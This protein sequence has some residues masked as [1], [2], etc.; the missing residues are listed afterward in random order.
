MQ[1][2]ATQQGFDL[3]VRV[4]DD[5]P[6]INADPDAIEQALHNMISNA[7][8][9]SG[10]SRVIELALSKDGASAVVSV[11]DHGIGILT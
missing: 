1:Y 11:T 10:D 7:M 6:L 5:V 4:D 8:K 9:Y 2:P 3:R